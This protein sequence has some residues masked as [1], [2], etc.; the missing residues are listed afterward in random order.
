MNNII[1]AVAIATIWV[2]SMIGGSLPIA[3]WNAVN[4]GCSGIFPG[5]ARTYVFVVGL[6]VVIIL[7]IIM[8]LYLRIFCKVWGRGRVQLYLHI[9]VLVILEYF[10]PK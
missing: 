6:H 10:D 9:Y 2:Y 7:V 8:V 3:G 5:L 4:Y 1:V